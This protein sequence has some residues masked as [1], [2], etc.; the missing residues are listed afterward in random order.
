M[1]EVNPYSTPEASADITDE[2]YQP[3]IFA[4]NGRIGRIRYLAYSMIYNLILYFVLGIAAAI[5]MGI[6]GDSGGVATGIVFLVLYIPVLVIFVALMR[7]R[8]NDLDKSGW[9]LLLLLVPLVNLIFGLYM[10][11]APGTKGVNRF[12]PA[13]VKTPAALWIL[14]LLL[15]F[16]MIVGILAA[17][18]L[19]AYQDYVERAKA[20]QIQFEE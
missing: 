5:L 13:P 16:I 10:I 4:L 7:R 15:P 18:A 11:F 20:A 6:L 12:G 14:G 8:I 19:P 17:V 2:L 3:K 1:S 9:L